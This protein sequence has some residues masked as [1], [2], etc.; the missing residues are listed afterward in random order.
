M[1][2]NKNYVLKTLGDETIL[3]HQDE[4]SVDMTKIINLNEIAIIIIKKIEENLSIE[5][6]VKYIVSNYD[7]DEETA[8][9]D[10]KEF[11]YELVEKGII[12]L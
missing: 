11:I 3:V 9:K 2:L 7:V 12:D 5:E 10:T 6:I 1:K 8:T 4:F